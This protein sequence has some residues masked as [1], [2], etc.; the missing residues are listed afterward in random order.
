VNGV[1]HEAAEGVD[2]G[3]GGELVD[4][5]VGDG[6]GQIAGAGTGSEGGEHGEGIVVGDAVE[7]RVAAGGKDVELLAGDAGVGSAEIEAPG[8]VGYEVGAVGVGGGAGALGL[9][10]EMLGAR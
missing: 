6:D 5:D 1:G 2:G 10:R 8:G 9:M 3:Y 4:G 7:A